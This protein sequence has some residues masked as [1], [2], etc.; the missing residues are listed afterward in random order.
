MTRRTD[1]R[2]F[3]PL[4]LLWG[5]AIPAAAQNNATSPLLDDREAR[6]IGLDGIRLLM[7][8]DPD[9][10]IAIFRRIQ[11][12]YP[13]S[14]LGYLLEGD[15]TWWK[16]YY[17][18]ADLVEAD[19]FDIVSTDS[20]PYDSHFEDL[21]SVAIRKSEARL[22][23]HQD[24]A[25]NSLYLGLA[26]ALRARLAGLRGK[27]LPTARAGKRMRAHLLR[28]RR[29]DPNLADAYLGLGLYN[30]FVDTLPA[31]V[32]VLRMFIALPGGSRTLGLEQLQRAADEGE[33]C[34]F[35]AKFLLAKD[36]S[37]QNEAKY[38]KSLELFQELGRE[39]PHN[40]L[41]PFLVGNI[42]CRLG[43]NQSCTAAY[44]QALEQTADPRGDVDQAV[45]AA[46]Y[47]ALGRL[48]GD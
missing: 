31:I 7:D 35:E 48:H 28:A 8:G 42:Q 1:L 45:H 13:Q 40:P 4:I 23:A 6:R 3:L 29:L 24:E 25:L 20:S 11:S 5:A 43:D 33:I 2:G 16:I 17:S 21:V 30:Y 26:Y 22:A 39:F 27:D 10:S 14:P 19:V 15:A 34:R 38:S 9:G 37:R 47:Q 41:W 32:K 36:Y 46:A 18:T 44:R 12:K